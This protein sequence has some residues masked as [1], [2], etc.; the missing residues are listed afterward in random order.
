MA[1]KQQTLRGLGAL[2]SH[3]GAEICIVAPQVCDTVKVI[4]T[5]LLIPSIGR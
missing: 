2:I 1:S 4:S 3:V 5:R